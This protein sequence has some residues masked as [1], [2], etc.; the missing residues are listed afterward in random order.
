MGKLNLFGGSR[1]DGATMNCQGRCRGFV[2]PLLVAALTF[3]FA[4][5]ARSEG[6]TQLEYLQWLAQLSGEAG[7]FSKNSTS[8][9]FA[10]WAADKGMSPRNGWNLSGK[11]TRDVLGETLVQF[12]RLNPGKQ[13]DVFQVLGRHG[14][15]LP[16]GEVSRKHLALLVNNNLQPKQGLFRRKKSP[17]RPDRDRDQDTDVDRDRDRDRDRD[18]DRSDDRPPPPPRDRDR[19]GFLIFQAR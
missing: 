3:V 13:T 1:E 15:S 17:P 9:D 14:I 12:L 8:Q 2:T 6:I 11:L 18:N 10:K 7:S 5:N 4:A 19:G 16:S